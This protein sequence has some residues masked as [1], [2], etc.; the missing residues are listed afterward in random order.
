MSDPIPDFPGFIE[1]LVQDKGYECNPCSLSCPDRPRA[2]AHLKDPNIE[3][4]EDKNF[5]AYEDGTYSPW[6]LTQACRLVYP[7]RRRK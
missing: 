7:V 6:D 4:P 1:Y 5:I 3:N 2:H